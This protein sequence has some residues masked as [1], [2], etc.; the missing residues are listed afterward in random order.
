MELK[1]IPTATM[2][3]LASTICGQGTVIDRKL[4]Q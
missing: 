1:H 2:L 3:L 4:N